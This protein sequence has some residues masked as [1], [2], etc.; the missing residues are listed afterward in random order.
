LDLAL[1][2]NQSL[3]GLATASSLFLVSAGLSIIFGVTRIVNFAHGSFYMLGAYG[4]YWI[5]ARLG[6]GP[7]G[8][9]GAIL[10]AAL[11]VGAVG[12]AVEVL[13]LRRIYRA[14]ELFQLLAT[15]GLVLIAGDGVVMLFGPNDLVAPRA[16][17]LK[18]ALLVLGRPYPAYE[19]ALIVLGPAVLALLWWLFHR[20]R[21]GT[22]VRAATLDREMVGA[23]GVN[24]ARL[25][26]S[27]FFVGTLL[28]G[29][30]GAVQLPREAIH[31][32]MDLQVITEAFVVVVVGG[33]G[34]LPG[35]F[36]AALLIGELHAFGILLFPKITLVLI[37]LVMAAVLVIR[38]WG[39]LG[40]PEGLA[41]VPGLVWEAPLRMRG[42]GWTLVFRGGALLLL[43]MPWVSGGYT[44]TV[45]TEVII[46]A[47][48]AASLHF[49]MGAGGM[50]SFGH[51]AYFGL[52]SYGAALAVKYLALPLPAALAA[53]VT[54][55]GLGALA[56]GWGSV[57][58]SGVYMAMLTL[59]FAQ[60]AYAV[61]FQWY[62]L[63]G[64]DNGLLGIWPDAWASNR[65]VFY[66]LTL[67][68]CGA[69]V[70]ALRHLHDSP[71]GYGLRAL[72]DSPLRAEALGMDRRRHQWSAFVLAGLFAGLA[73]G[74][75]AFFKGSVFPDNLGIPMS[76]DSLVMVL[77][78]GV[79]A[80][81]GPLAGALVYKTLHLAVATVTDR[82][83][84]VLGFII[85]GLVIA[86]PHGLVGAL[87]GLAGS[88]DPSAAPGK[89]EGSA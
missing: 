69:A 4:A 62:E 84:F 73:G 68:L 88:E 28:A 13:L 33:L 67:A 51:A 6:T 46:M 54:A 34:S 14:P 31:H 55:A 43:L 5:M 89:R 57:R 85:V 7:L 23:L 21:W 47:L 37:F 75:F 53:G 41:R 64:G 26:T 15:F 32:Q 49:L 8:Y 36:L 66:Y 29:L 81:G 10:L 63:T 78:G 40:R 25:F 17:G 60:I 79:N 56:F 39:L 30:G 61:S 77:L 76:L 87:R 9:Y 2:V 16:P 65:I 72:R 1:I 44:L 11:A 83:Q 80:L 71:F 42:R 27:V 82:W 74:L 38:P 48:F 59:A 70:L 3:N 18:G 58:L 50:A 86:F 22:L 52:G 12:A 24:Q 35:A 20:T 45:L 19:A